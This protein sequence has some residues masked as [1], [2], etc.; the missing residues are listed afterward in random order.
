MKGSNS[1]GQQLAYGGANDLTPAGGATPGQQGQHGGKDPSDYPSRKDN[2]DK[3]TNPN[4]VPL[5]GGGSKGGGGFGGRG[6]PTQLS[7]M[8]SAGGQSDKI[9]QKGNARSPSRIAAGAPQ[10]VTHAQLDAANAEKQALL[11]ATAHA[12]KSKADVIKNVLLNL[13]GQ[14]LSATR[15]TDAR[16][17]EQNARQLLAQVTGRKIPAVVP[18]ETA[19]GR[20]AGAAQQA[21][22]A[23]TSQQLYAAV[24]NNQQYP[25]AQQLGTTT[26]APGGH[27]QYPVSAQPTV[28][29][30]NLQQAPS[31]NL[32]ASFQSHL[33]AQR[34]QQAEAAALLQGSGKVMVQTNQTPAKKEEEEEDQEMIDYHNLLLG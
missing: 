5:G 10:P 13:H 29:A 18:P 8:A 34:Q 11:Q 23:P 31:A 1:Y 16:V 28:S 14:N 26:S 12:E 6:M 25:A 33:N 30:H 20:P 9:N 21:T 3:N 4:L 27:Q 22:T 15:P 17:A 2:R 24:G 19:G 32:L 7:S